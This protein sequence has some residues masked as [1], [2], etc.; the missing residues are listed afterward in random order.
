M[1][2]GW[3]QLLAN[4]RGGDARVGQS[5]W[6]LGIRLSRWFDQLANLLDA[7]RRFVCGLLPSPP[8]E[9]VH[10]S[11][12][13]ASFPQARFDGGSGESPFLLGAPGIAV[14]VLE[15]DFRQ[16]LTPLKSRELL[17]GRSNRFNDILS[18]LFRMLLVQES[19]PGRLLTRI[20]P[21][22]G[23]L[24]SRGCLNQIAA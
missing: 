14:A 18:E 1:G 17:R 3:E 4:I 16:K 9:G 13:G 20:T 2:S 5:G 21:I 19:P 24:F 12:A 23:R 10:A 8:L 22:P 6:K 15:R 11:P 7:V